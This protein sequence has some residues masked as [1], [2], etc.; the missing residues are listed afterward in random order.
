MNEKVNSELIEMLNVFNERVIQKF[1][2]AKRCGALSGD[3]NDTVIAKIVI[4]IVADDVRVFDDE[5]KKI[6]RNLRKF[7]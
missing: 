3:E 7:I 5:H 2:E 4:R 1:H 6:E